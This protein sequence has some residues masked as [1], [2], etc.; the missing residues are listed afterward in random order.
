MAS[1]IFADAQAELAANTDTTVYTV[2]ASTLST[3]TV[4]FCNKGNTDA[5]IRLAIREDGDTLADKHYLEYATVIPGHTAFERTGL[6]A[7]SE[8]EVDVKSTSGEVSV[9]VYGF[10]EAV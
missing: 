2:P 4:S 1:G 9:S 6:V 3:F 7:S 8:D 10:E 5:Q